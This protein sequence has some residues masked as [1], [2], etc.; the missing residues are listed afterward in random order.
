[1]D[2]VLDLG[3]DDDGSLLSEGMMMMMIRSIIWVTRCTA[4]RKKK[5]FTV[6]AQ[7]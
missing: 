6:T 4:T 7:H 1:M 3:F 5:T 2:H